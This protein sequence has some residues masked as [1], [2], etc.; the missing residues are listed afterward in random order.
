M[1]AEN[2][3]AILVI[4]DDADITANLADILEDCGYRSVQANDGVTALELLKTSKFAVALL[5]FKIPDM[6]GATLFTK[7]K[8]CQPDIVAIMVTAYAGSD[9]VQRAIDAG[10][11]KVLAKP[12][13][14]GML[15]EY[16]AEAVA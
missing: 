3:P 9:G 14:V 8:E 11:W 2:N 7:I 4:D 6:D 5:D 13:D 1:K 12:V 16:V 10:T 15:L